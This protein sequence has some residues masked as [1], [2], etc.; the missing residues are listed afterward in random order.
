TLDAGPVPGDGW[1]VRLT[2]PRPVDPVAPTI[3]ERS[4][5]SADAPGSAVGQEAP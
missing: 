5:T 4:A 3:P 2:V 1:R